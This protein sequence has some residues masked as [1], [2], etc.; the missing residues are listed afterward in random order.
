MSKEEILRSIKNAESEAQQTL[1]AAEQKAQAIV[2]R[3]R[4]AASDLSKQVAQLAQDEAQQ[5]I[6][7]ARQAATATAEKVAEDGA[8]AL[9]AIRSNGKKNRG[10]AVDAVLTAFMG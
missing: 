9:S 4:G 10:K 3:S 8:G 1:E 5:V 2:T 6:E 7:A